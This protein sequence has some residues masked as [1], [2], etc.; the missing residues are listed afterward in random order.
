MLKRLIKAGV[1]RGL[2]PAWVGYRHVPRQT[3]AQYFE[4]HPEQR[5]GRYET[6]HREAVAH[7]PLPRNVASRDQLPADRGWWGYSFHDVPAR[8]SDETFIATLPDCRVIAYRDPDRGDDFYPAILSG[9]RRA[10][11]LREIRFRPRHAEALRHAGPPVRLKKATWFIERVYHNHSHWLTAH[12]PKLL[13]LRDRG[14]LADVVLP[15]ER[16]PAIDG[17]LRMLGIDAA[18]FRTFD[19]ARPLDVEEFTFLGTDRFRPE[20]LR[21]VPQAFGVLDAEPPRRKVFISRGKALRRRLV[22]EDEV[23]ALLEPRGFERVLMEELSFQQQVELMK[24]TAVLVAPHGAGL[25][26]MMFC[27]PGAH[28]VEMADLSFPNPNFYALASAMGH[29]YWVIKADALG[30][31]HPLEKDLRADV[32]ALAEVLSDLP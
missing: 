16:T 1:N 22:N 19:L 28:V 10:L 20:L 14:A 8:T 5:S 4:G 27:P 29:H 7:N 17:S 21:L 3:V 2:D 13:L 18:Q 9:D 11:D 12:L 24:Q 23:W 26:N 30:D 6:V 15:E 32:R 31:V 25:T